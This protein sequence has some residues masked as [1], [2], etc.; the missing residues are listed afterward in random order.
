MKTVS[1]NVELKERSKSIFSKKT[2]ILECQ[3]DVPT[4]DPTSLNPFDENNNKIFRVEV[5]PVANRIGV[6]TD[7]S[8]VPDTGISGLNQVGVIS[9]MVKSVAAVKIGDR[10]YA[11]I[12]GGIDMPLEGNAK[13]T[14]I[15]E[16]WFTDQDTAN[17]V[18]LAAAEIE[19]EKAVK[20]KEEVDGAVK[21]LTAIND[22]YGS[23]QE[24]PSSFGVLTSKKK[25]TKSSMTE[26]DLDDIKEAVEEALAEA[27]ESPLERNGSYDDN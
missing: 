20:M 7:G 4:L 25:S 14:N 10:T 12:N 19:L 27:L 23:S 18:C 5:K 6:F 8:I 15:E 2:N 11:R 1:I 26:E 22:L 13:R 24:R 17:A 3:L 16:A 9:E 21:V